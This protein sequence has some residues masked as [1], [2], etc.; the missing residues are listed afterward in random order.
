MSRI[1]NNPINIPDKVQVSLNGNTISV[2][3]PKG[4]M[5]FEKNDNIILTQEDNTI[6]FSR[7]NNEKI[8]RSLHGTTRAVVDNMVTGVSTGFKKELDIEGVGFKAEMKKD[9][10]FLS[11]G[12]SHPILVLPPDGVQFTTP[13][14]T[15]IEI[16]GN[17]KQIV[18]EVA[19]KI[20]SL[21]KPEPYK[22]KGIRYSGEYIRRKAGK[23]AAK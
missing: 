19:S 11:L 15:K 1:G 12:Y 6:K 16:N 21:R 18:G 17:N 14:P 23:S 3:G 2:K 7:E 8:T 20:R 9:R 4:E 22:G 5:T 10:L 13:T